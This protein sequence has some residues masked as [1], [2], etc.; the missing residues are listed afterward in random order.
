LSTINFVP[1][2]TFG[3]AAYLITLAGAQRAL[4]KLNIMRY[5]VDD[6]LFCYWRNGLRTY[7]LYPYPV[8]QDG[9]QSTI[10]HPP[11]FGGQ[12][13]RKK[14]LMKAYRR[15]PKEI[16]KAKRVAFQL[17]HFGMNAFKKVPLASQ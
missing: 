12:A 5:Q 10:D 1:A 7:E 16:D 9:S 14:L 4:Q 17:R 8:R 2:P 13:Q 15:L 3:A 11:M 6:D